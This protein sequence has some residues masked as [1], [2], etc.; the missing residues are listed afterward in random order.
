[1]AL[2]PFLLIEVR[3][4][5]RTCARQ[6]ALRTC[7]RQNAFRKAS[8]LSPTLAPARFLRS[9]PANRSPAR[10]PTT[11]VPDAQSSSAPKADTAQSGERS[12]QL[13]P[14]REKKEA[15]DTGRTLD[16]PLRV[17]PPAKIS[18]TT[19][20]LP[21]ERLHIEHLTRHPPPK[22]KMPGFRETVLVYHLGNLK[23]MWMIFL[24]VFTT[25]SACVMATIWMPA[26]Y[27]WGA[28]L[29][30]LAT[31]GLATL[32]PTWMIT[33]WFR[34]VITEIRLKLPP[35]ARESA[36]TAMDYARN[37]PRDAAI[38]V[39]CH[40]W[41]SLPAV[42]TMKIGD[43]VPVSKRINLPPV[44]FSH[45]FQ[46]M[47][48]DSSQPAEASTCTDA[49]T[50]T[51]RDIEILIAGFRSFKSA[52]EVDNAQLTAALGLSNP[53]STTNA[54]RNLT[55]K[56]QGVQVPVLASASKDVMTDDQTEK[57]VKKPATMST[58]PSVG[59]SENI[60]TL[61]P[62]AE[63]DNTGLLPRSAGEATPTD[64]G[65]KCQ[66]KCKEAASVLVPATPDLTG[67]DGPAANSP[68]KSEPA[69]PTPGPSAPA[70]PADQKCGSKDTDPAVA[71]VAEE[72][73][74]PTNKARK[75]PAKKPKASQANSE[76]GTPDAEADKPAP[77]KRKV[78]AKKAAKE[79]ASVDRAE[80]AAAHDEDEP[81]PKRQRKAPAKKPAASKQPK[82][83]AAGK[84]NDKASEAEAALFSAEKAE[85][86]AK[87][88]RINKAVKE[89]NAVLMGEA[90]ATSISGRLDEDTASVEQFTSSGTTTPTSAAKTVNDVDDV[91]DTKATDRLNAAIAAA[92]DDAIDSLLNLNTTA[93][94]I[95]TTSSCGCN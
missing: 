70:P 50:L 26:Y 39:R 44:S 38:Q 89:A 69:T 72:E 84:T 80:D 94:V 11:N 71:A 5:F 37:L 57:E 46:A 19:K 36:K 47:A 45:T 81:K 64:T 95:T 21:Q 42:V 25:T 76:T 40:Y 55:K 6:N 52:P 75:A 67:R 74:K 29:W 8:P 28:P 22:K 90:P 68:T 85:A 4:A 48:G 35:S 62:A 65:I 59:T 1:M 13:A 51:H 54:W 43:T 15:L 63:A 49:P 82:K 88:E 58:A 30:V 32:L 3:A 93:T 78:P 20:L 9:G 24:R 34:G 83:T 56:L 61:T 87:K 7:A 23:I 12:T 27:Q 18:P 92:F 31:V 60:T 33:Y 77:K 41:T 10:R 2:P 16:V 91:D 86:D 73:A 66:S 53:R 79:N 14:R 17:I